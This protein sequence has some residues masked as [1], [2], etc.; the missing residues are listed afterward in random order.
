M[1][2]LTKWKAHFDAFGIKYKEEVNGD[3]VHAFNN[4]TSLETDEGVGYGGFS[5]TVYFN[6]DGS[7]KYYGVW[8]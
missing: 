7:F 2:D 1:T 5:F 8:G 3:G 4:T 6:Q